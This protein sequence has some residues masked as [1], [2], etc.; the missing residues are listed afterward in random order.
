MQM[1]LAKPRRK[2]TGGTP[3]DCGYVKVVTMVER[4]P[5]LVKQSPKPLTLATDTENWWAMLTNDGRIER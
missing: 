2:A 5:P 3:S 4:T 1:R